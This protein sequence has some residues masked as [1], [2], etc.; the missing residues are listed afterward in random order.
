LGHKRGPRESC[1]DDDDGHPAAPHCPH[2]LTHR[3]DSTTSSLMTRPTA[4][5]AL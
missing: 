3:F 1:D 5:W 2:S 4:A